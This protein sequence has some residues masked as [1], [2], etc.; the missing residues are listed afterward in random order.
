MSTNNTAKLTI[1]GSGTSQ[2]VPVIA[3]QCPTCMSTDPKDQRLRASVLIELPDL[4][5]CIDAGPD[6][7]GQMLR[8]KVM[9]LDAILLTHEHKD[10]IAGLDDIR[11]FNFKR[12]DYFPVYCTPKV[13]TALK[14]EFYYAFEA[15]PYPG[16]PRFAIHHIDKG[17][18]QIGP[19][20]F[21][22][23]E[24]WHHQMQVLGF[25]F[26]NLAYIT[27]A[28]TISPEEKTRLLGLDTLIVN[29]LHEFPHP[30]HFNLAEALE[31]IQEIKPK[32]SYLTHISHLFGPNAE[33]SAKLPENVFLAYD[34]L[35]LQFDYS[36]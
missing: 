5:I 13:E 35:Q 12:Q 17:K 2:G 8:A 21:E 14:R 19:H 9:H 3:C 20:A 33:V 4:T 18:V 1:L 16:V 27:D 7:R 15:K 23:I 22:A 30:S 10:H 32:K 25:R 29:A 28:K 36:V 6:F 11:A 34:G 24:V 26:G 31:L